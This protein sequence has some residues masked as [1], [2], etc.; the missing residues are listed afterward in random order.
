MKKVAAGVFKAKC[1]A[2]MDEVQAKPPTIL[3][4]GLSPVRRLLAVSL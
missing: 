4:I 1:L 3:A 2:I